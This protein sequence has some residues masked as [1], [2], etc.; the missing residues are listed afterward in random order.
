[1][2]SVS[3]AIR[4]VSKH[5][6]FISNSLSLDLSLTPGAIDILQTNGSICLLAHWLFP[7]YPTMC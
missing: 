2:I 5:G 4:R 3:L 7:V 1:M 6:I